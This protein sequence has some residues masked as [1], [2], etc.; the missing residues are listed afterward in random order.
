MQPIEHC[1][2]FRPAIGFATS[3]PERELPLA[4]EDPRLTPGLLT[5]SPDAVRIS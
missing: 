4:R 1:I 3:V 5:W 2:I